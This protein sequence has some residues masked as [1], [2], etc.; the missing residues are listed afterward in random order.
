MTDCHSVF[1][2][3]FVFCFVIWFYYEFVVLFKPSV[4]DFKQDF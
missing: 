2:C 3:N 4:F 1:F